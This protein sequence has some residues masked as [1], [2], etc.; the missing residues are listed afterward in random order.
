MMLNVMQAS[1]RTVATNYRH[2]TENPIPVLPD[3]TSPYIFR[4]E[5]KLPHYVLTKTHCTGFQPNAKFLDD[6]ATFEQSCR[7][8]RGSTTYKAS[9]ID[10]MIHLIRNP[11]DNVVA[12]KHFLLKAQTQQKDSWTLQHLEELDD[13]IGGMNRWCQRQDVQSKVDRI[14]ASRYPAKD[15]GSLPCR[16]LFLKYTLWHNM[17]LAATAHLPTLVV[18]YEDYN[19]E[20][21]NETVGR[22]MNFLELTVVDDFLPFQDGHTYDSFDNTTKQLAG[23]LIQHVASPATWEHLKRY[24][25]SAPGLDAVLPRIDSDTSTAIDV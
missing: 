4:P 2:E 13:S 8:L 9:L 16:S 22:I 5:Y 23:E 18:H 12:R 19:P 7:T 20:T 25:G 11:F 3:E 1:Q 14:L 21:Y 6:V 17:A 10:K 24:M 15:F